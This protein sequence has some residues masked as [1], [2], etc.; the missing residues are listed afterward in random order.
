MNT[1]APVNANKEYKTC[2][3]TIVTPGSS[4]QVIKIFPA[5][6][7]HEKVWL[8]HRPGI[9]RWESIKRLMTQFAP[10]G[11]R[12]PEPVAYHSSSKNLLVPEISESD[13]PVVK[14]EGA[15]FE[16][17]P[18]AQTLADLPPNLNPL[19]SVMNERMAKLEAAV[20]NISFALERLADA[21]NDVVDGVP[22][23]RGRKPRP[24]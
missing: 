14:L 5:D 18:A 6:H 4:D 11:E 16:A 1:V 21:K 22:A 9:E 13:I 15:V 10:R 24:A 8:D 12:V 3:V 23:R 20:E 2:K 19:P 7:D 17:L